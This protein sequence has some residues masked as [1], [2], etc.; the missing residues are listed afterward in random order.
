MFVFS[1]R[2][3][4][5]LREDEDAPLLLCILLLET[6]PPCVDKAD[7][8]EGFMGRVPPPMPAPKPPLLLPT[9]VMVIVCRLVSTND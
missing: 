1:L 5:L 8:S 2:L 6:K 4:L 7:A 3:L 9:V